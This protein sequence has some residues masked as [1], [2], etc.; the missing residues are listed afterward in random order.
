M[1]SIRNLKKDVNYVFGDI[2]DAV[3]HWEY[4][5]DNT[6]SQKGSELIKEII[7]TY[8]GVMDKISDKKVENRAV[9]L[10]QVRKEFEQKAGEFIV[11][12]NQL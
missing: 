4:A 3:L 1:A 8:D 11:K 12:L 10:K 5:T 7:S 6:E 2:I 9:H